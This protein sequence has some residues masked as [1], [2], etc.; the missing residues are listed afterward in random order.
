MDVKELY[1]FSTWFLNYGQKVS[2]QYEKLHQKLKHNATQLE[3]QTIRDDL[4]VL[5]EILQTMP[6]HMLSNEQVDLLEKE[7]VR[8]FVGV[9]GV[10]NINR[11]V[12]SGRFD[13]ASAAADV[14]GIANL[15]TQSLT[16]I[17]AIHNSLS[18]MD[19]FV[20][21]ESSYKQ[22]TIR[23]HFKES[24]AIS[25]MAEWK[26]WADEWYDIIRGVTM[27]VDEAPE[28]VKVIGA[29]Q[30]SVI[31]V[32]GATAA[33]TGTLLVI[34]SHLTKIALNALQVANS[35]ADFKHKLAINDTI[36]D[37]LE[38]AIAQ[39][40]EE[41]LGVLLTA[42]K[43]SLPVRINGE[44]ENALKRSI[45]KYK[46]FTEQGGEVDFISPP[47]SDENIYEGLDD[48]EIESITNVREN[49]VELRDTREKIRL[50]TS[51]SHVEEDFEDDDLDDPEE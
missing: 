4:N 18:E 13:P 33:V 48:A 35:F 45:D 34:S 14:Q 9:S 11:M 51:Q 27:C 47:E 21:E 10:Q 50:V 30:G 26:K 42:A 36:I 25:D 3:K 17:G 6:L 2:D 23:L 29:H 24:A 8:E 12:K 20:D 31:M 32:L 39:Y 28:N 16:R 37:G 1:Y 7:G 15:L 22:I 5:L 19:G 44:Q 43:E 41:A 38:K 40:E 46:K 49:I